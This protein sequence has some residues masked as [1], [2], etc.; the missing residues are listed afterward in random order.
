MREYLARGMERQIH[1]RFKCRR[2][3]PWYGVPGVWSADAL[4]LRQAGEMPRLIHLEEECV[5][6]DT[7]HRVRWR[8]PEL[9]KRYAAAFLNTWTLLACELTGR[10][11]GGGVLELMPS[12]ANALP[13]PPPVEE[14]ET[15]FEVVDGLVRSRQL[16]AAVEMV[17][18]V[19]MPAS[20]TPE[21][22]DAARNIRAKLVS[23][24]RGKQNG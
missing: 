2:R 18:R 8:R 17:D 16:D 1:L 7:I 14:L 24:R 9:G 4:L 21:E 10:S 23:R 11:Y 15:I 20:I 12:E 13:L 6:T 5:S 19:V 3:E 22:H